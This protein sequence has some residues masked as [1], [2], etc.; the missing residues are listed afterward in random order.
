MAAVGKRGAAA[1][2]AEAKA[3]AAAPSTAAGKGALGAGSH[4]RGK[5]GAGEVAARDDGATS[6][7]AKV[8]ADKAQ[9]SKAAEGAM[10][11]KGA[12]VITDMSTW[13]RPR[14]E[15]T[16][17]RCIVPRACEMLSMHC[18]RMWQPRQQLYRPKISSVCAIPSITICEIT[19]RCL[20]C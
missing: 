2:R 14:W 1:A 16:P 3:A 18:L 6:K 11:A 19:L 20:W 17:S 4:A 8:A 12:D 9:A 10:A 15:N 5:R 13:K 7:K